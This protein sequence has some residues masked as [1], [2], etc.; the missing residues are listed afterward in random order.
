MTMLLRTLVFAGLAVLLATQIPAVMTL[1]DRVPEPASGTADMPSSAKALPASVSPA[2]VRL[3][4]DGRGHFSGQFR[5]NGKTVEGLVDTGASA[6]TINESTARRLGFGV[7]SLD[8]RYQMNTANGKTD[9][10]RVIL[11]RIE[12]GNVRVRQVDAFVLRDEALSG[13]LIGMTFLKKLKSFQVED[14]SLTLIP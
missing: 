4:A 10:A 7:N 6:V 2:R 9:G 13:T 3:S 8:F 5:I 12:I 1:V 14:G 11:D